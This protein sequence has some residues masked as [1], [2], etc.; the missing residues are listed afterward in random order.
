MNGNVKNDTNVYVSID[1]ADSYVR[2]VYQDQIKQ[3]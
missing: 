2:Q 1:L 3:G